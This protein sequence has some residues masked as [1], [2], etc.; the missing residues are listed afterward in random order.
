M[1]SVLYKLNR[2]PNQNGCVCFLRRLK[3]DGFMGTGLNEFCA[4]AAIPLHG[5]LLFQLTIDIPYLLFEKFKGV[6]PKFRLGSPYDNLQNNASRIIDCRTALQY[7]PEGIRLHLLIAPIPMHSCD[8]SNMCLSMDSTWALECDIVAQYGNVGLSYRDLL[9][10]RRFF[11]FAD[12]NGFIYEAGTY[13]T[14]V[15]GQFDLFSPPL[16][17]ICI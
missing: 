6:I 1:E 5:D 2:N 7:T 15:E 8:F 16:F 12:L 11:S 10:P 17:A 9:V 3:F 4:L 14:W 13:F